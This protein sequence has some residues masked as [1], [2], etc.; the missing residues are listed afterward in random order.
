M[1]ANRILTATL[2]L[3]L[4]VACRNDDTE[5]TNALAPTQQ[6]IFSGNKQ[7]PHIALDSFQRNVVANIPAG[8]TEK[9][10]YKN[11]YTLHRGKDSITV[12]GV[13]FTEGENK[14]LTSYRYYFKASGKYCYAYLKQQYID[15]ANS[16]GTQQLQSREA[17]YH[18]HFI[19]GIAG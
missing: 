4:F 16:K 14:T 11:A 2:F 3:L 15:G 5:A 12:S 17:G 8:S 6:V 18:L 9:H 7:A 10:S 19:D 13:L 1:K